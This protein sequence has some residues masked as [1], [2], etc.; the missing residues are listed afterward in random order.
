MCVLPSNAWPAAC[1]FRAHARITAP[2]FLCVFPPADV[3][4]DGAFKAFAISLPEISELLDK[5]PEADPLL[6]H[7]VLKSKHGSC[8]PACQAAFAGHQHRSG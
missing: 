1:A 7:E 6:L 3:S 4:V 2:R 5:L 8:I